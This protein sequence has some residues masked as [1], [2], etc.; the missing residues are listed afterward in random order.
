MDSTD[1]D[2][3]IDRFVAGLPVDGDELSLAVSAR[4]VDAKIV[5]D[6][7]LCGLENDSPVARLHAAKRVARMIELAP[8]LEVRLRQLA[9][10]DGDRR[11][12]ARASAVLRAHARPVPGEEG[13][14]TQASARLRS[15]PSLWLRPAITRGAGPVRS[16]TPRAPRVVRSFQAREREEAPATRG[17][18]ITQDG[19]LRID[20]TGLPEAFIG[21]RLAVFVHGDATEVMQLAVASEP[22]DGAGGVSIPIERRSQTLEEI[23]D[24]LAAELEL[25]VVVEED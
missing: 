8:R 6:A 22:V 4:A 19:E 25:A 2:R 13:D 10:T 20:L 11:V 18:A 7:L 15:L 5:V 21:R 24:L 1:G 12:R 16:G 9:A 17:R 14:V 3:A 23:V